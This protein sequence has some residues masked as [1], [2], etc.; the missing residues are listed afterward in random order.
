[1]RAQ[2]LHSAIPVLL[3]ETPLNFHYS[4]KD[5]ESVESETGSLRCT[6]DQA[7]VRQEVSDLAKMHA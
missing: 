3:V 7:K 6:V 2:N 5:T 4:N 1:M